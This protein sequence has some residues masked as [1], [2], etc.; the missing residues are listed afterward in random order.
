MNHSWWSTLT[1][2]LSGACLIILYWCPLNVLFVKVMLTVSLPSW[3]KL[4][5][6]LPNRTSRDLIQIL[7]LWTWRHTLS[8]TYTVHIRR[9]I[10][11]IG[12][13]MSSPGLTDE[14]VWI[15]KLDGRN[16][17]WDRVG[18]PTK[19]TVTLQSVVHNVFQSPA[20]ELPITF[21]MTRWWFQK[22]FMFTPTWGNN[23]IWRIFFR[24]GSK[25]QLDE[26][27]WDIRLTLFDV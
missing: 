14:I 7:H 27:D 23:P 20:F 8:E 6:I 10:D 4:T 15:C 5:W 3:Y 21:I 16:P 24:L 18:Y 9:Y 26:Y 22:I 25:H 11:W 1:A 17:N 13:N 12:W 2:L 19:C